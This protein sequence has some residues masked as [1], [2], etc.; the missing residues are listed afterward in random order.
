MVQD[1]AIQAIEV[2]IN[3][4]LEDSGDIFIVS[5]KI[6]PTNNIKVYLDA[7]SGLSIEKCIK[8][9]RA[10]YKNIEE[11]GW[12]PDGNFS[13][14]VSSPGV[15]EPLKSLRQYKKNIGRKVE[16]TLLDGTKKEGK[17]T[18]VNDEAFTIEYVEGKNKK[19][20]TISSDITFADVKQT[21]VVI[22][23]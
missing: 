20:V 16:V 17:L 1:S 9:N 19:A 8:I 11:E 3:K 23:F 22:S 6:K 7:D 4:L 14:E 13:L 21:T 15:D 10:L 5:V 2:L 12:Y 18:A